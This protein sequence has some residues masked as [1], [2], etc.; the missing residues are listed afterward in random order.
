MHSFQWAVDTVEKYTEWKRSLGLYVGVET[1]K[2]LNELESNILSL[3]IHS[4]GNVVVLYIAT[5]TSK[6]EI[7][8]R[9]S[10]VVVQ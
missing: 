3:D 1:Q 9:K 5:R 8:E 10:F 2:S 6:D 4:E 7:N